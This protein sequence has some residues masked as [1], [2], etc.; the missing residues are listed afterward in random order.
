VTQ[1]G[2]HLLSATLS[3]AVLP[4]ANLSAEKDQEYF[5][6][7][8]AEEIINLLAHIAGLRVI[9]RTSKFRGQKFRGETELALWETEPP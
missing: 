5:S 6:D 8:L 1:S 7:G 9:A 2:A 3:I 4:F